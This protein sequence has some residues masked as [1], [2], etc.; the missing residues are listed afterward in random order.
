MADDIEG[1][2]VTTTSL[3]V[4]RGE[5]VIRLELRNDGWWSLSFLGA[6]GEIGGAFPDLETATRVAVECVVPLAEA[7][8]HRANYLIA[9]AIPSEIVTT[10]ANEHPN[11]P[12]P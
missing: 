8:E 12:G 1:T 11:V 5:A 10:A 9:M 6:T 4:T 2:K 3:M 7:M